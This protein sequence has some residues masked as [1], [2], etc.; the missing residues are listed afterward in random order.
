[1]QSA[2]T[3]YG[4]PVMHLV[5]MSILA[6]PASAVSCERVFSSAKETTTVRRNRILPEM[7]EA[8]QVLKYRLVE[9]L[10]FTNGW[11]CTEDELDISKDGDSDS[12]I[13]SQILDSTNPASMSDFAALL[14]GS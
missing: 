8:L 2:Q 13:L 11:I 6:I 4:Y 9:S 7:M 10:R 12:N 14:N 1:M 3:K 5:A